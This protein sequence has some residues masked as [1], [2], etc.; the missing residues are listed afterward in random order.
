MLVHD[1]DQLLFQELEFDI[2]ADTFTSIEDDSI[3]V[4]IG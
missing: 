2:Q 4:I 1:G 3:Q